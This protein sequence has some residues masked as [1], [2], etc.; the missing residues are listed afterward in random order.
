M[1]VKHID[2]VDLKNIKAEFSS[3]KRHRYSL[4]IPMKNR[5]GTK[6]LCVIGQNPSY[7]S[8]LS[9]DK[10]IRYIETYV[11]HNMPNFSKI[12]ILNLYT[13]VDTQK[14]ENDDLL[15]DDY[16]AYLNKIVSHHEDYLIVYGKLNNLGNYRFTDKAKELKKLLKGK[17]VMKFD[18]TGADYAPHPGNP[19]IMYHN[20]SIGLK[21]YSFIDI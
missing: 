10:T 8:E 20:T 19:K 18:V 12:L 2:A 3:D 16:S 7:A 14:D 17:N 5:T 1:T 11:F 21:Q 9:A 15:A 13:R 6:T 4:L